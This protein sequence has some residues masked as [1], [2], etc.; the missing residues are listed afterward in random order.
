MWELDSEESWAQKKWCFWA[1]VLE[2]TLE[3]P[4]DCK[5]IQPV[6]PEGDKSWVFI[7]RTDAK[8]ET[9][10]LWPPHVKSWL[11]GKEG[12]GAGG[13]G[14]DRAWDGW[15]VSLT[16]WAWV[17]VNSRSLWLTGRPGVL[18]FMGSQ[19]VGHDWA[20]ELNGTEQRQEVH[21]VSNWGS[22]WFVCPQWT[23]LTSNTFVGLLPDLKGNINL[24][25]YAFPLT[26]IIQRIHSRKLLNSWQRE[27]VTGIHPRESRIGI[28]L[29][30]LYF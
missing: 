21:W 5:E 4:L 6:Y 30:K 14:D 17:W 13:E 1:V 23:N 10:I 9:P 8:A 26:F 3:H 11:V 7:G 27:T 29:N 25:K 12:L 18:Q 19:R 20:T 22:G 24:S 2:N 28:W 15:M 16:R